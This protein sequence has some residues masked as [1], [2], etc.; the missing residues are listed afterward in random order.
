LAGYDLKIV[1]CPGNVNGKPNALSRR[2]DHR[3]EK[4]DRGQN[5]L[6]RIS[7]VLKPEYFVLEMMLKD[8]G[9][10]TVISGSKLQAVPPIKFN[11]D[12]MKRIV[13]AVRN[14]Q[15]WQEAYN[16]ARDGNPSANV[17][18]LYEALY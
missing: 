6:Q 15:E 5:G 18:Y 16:A 11:A 13:T 4:G 7:P 17:K 1:Y 3:P 2:P 12:F 14:D 10:W 9:V 8:I